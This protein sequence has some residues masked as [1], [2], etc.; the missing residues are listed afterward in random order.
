VGIFSNIRRKTEMVDV[1]IQDT[2][3]EAIKIK[4]IDFTAAQPVKKPRPSDVRASVQ[5]REIEDLKQDLNKMAGALRESV[6]LNQDSVGE[7]DKLSRFLKTAE[8]NTISMERLTP[9]N[10]QLKTALAE[11][12]GELSKKTLWA[13]ELESKAV[14]YK[15]RFEETHIDLETCRARVSEIEEQLYEQTSR[16]TESD[17]ALD[18]LQSERRELLVMIEDLKSKNM[19]I[20]DEVVSQQAN[21]LTLSRQNTELEKQ[22]ELFGAQTDD[23]RRKREAAQSDLKI[24]RLDYAELK[25]DQMEALSKFDKA[26]H[27]IEASGQTLAD[28]RQRSDD[29]IFALTSAIEGLKAQNKIN[30]DMSRYDDMEKAKLKADAQRHRSLA[31]DLTRQVEQKTREMDDSRAALKNAKGNYEELN[32]KFL[33][34]LSEMETLRSDHKKKSKKLDEYSSISGVAVGQSFYDD[35]QISSRSKPSEM[36]KPSLKLVKESPAG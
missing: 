22:V 16:C 6:R 20:Q 9:E 4:D 35:N 14:A 11:A 5:V 17:Q 31:A 26:R 23:E 19:T 2:K 33:A 13:S 18:K 27:E 36:G 32:G 10:S 8:V 3:V 28:F 25:S 12:Q 29:K 7:I 24:I 34:L 30:E 21:G 1:N 15:A